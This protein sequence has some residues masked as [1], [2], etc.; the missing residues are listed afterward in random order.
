MQREIIDLW[1]DIGSEGYWS[2]LLAKNPGIFVPFSERWPQPGFI[3]SHYFDSDSRVVVLGQNPRASNT[4]TTAEADMEMFRLI[5]NHS[6]E[7]S[8][9]SIVELFS[10][11]RSFML[12]IDYGRAWIPITTVRRHLSLALDSV[13]YLNLIP[14]ATSEDR[15]VPAFEYAYENSTMLQLQSLNPDKI[16]VFGKGTYDRFKYLGGTDQYEARYV[17]QRSY[18]RDAPPVRRWLNR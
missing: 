1:A 15:I 9:E 4:V 6:Q 2:D 7:R 14:L 17:G 10:M 8:A 3:G 12:G 16:V 18:S 11:I 5:R 13:A